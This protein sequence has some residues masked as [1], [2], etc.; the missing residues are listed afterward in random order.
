M[1]PLSLYWGELIPDETKLTSFQ[2]RT[3]LSLE[4]L[5][6]IST[7]AT[8]PRSLSSISGVRANRG[9]RVQFDNTIGPYRGG[10]RFHL[11]VKL[12]ILKSWASSRLQKQP[13]LTMM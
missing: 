5:Q 11:S 8:L 12:S 1:T 6:A 7:A 2:R 10:L 9:Y 4:A 3:H 13:D